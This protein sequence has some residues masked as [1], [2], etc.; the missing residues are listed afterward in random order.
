MTTI[1]EILTLVCVTAAL[2]GEW[3]WS[4]T[5]FLLAMLTL[6]PIAFIGLAL[7]GVAAL[8]FAKLH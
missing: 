5:A 4:L 8:L 1:T 6:S 2:C 7:L 3:R